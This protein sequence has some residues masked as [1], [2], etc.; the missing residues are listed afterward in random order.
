MRL[1][2][3]WF[4]PGMV[5]ATVLAWLFPEPGAAGGWLHPELL[6]KVGIALIFF[7]HGVAL[8][9]AALKAGTLRWPLHL[10]VQTSTFLLFP[11]LG[12]GLMQ[13]LGTKVPAE[14]ALGCFYYVRFRPR[15]RRRSH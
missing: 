15:Y 14:L 9:F 11:V 12:L 7:L 3:D 5:F 13:L 8:S 1:K 2:F 6:T 4:L 10:V